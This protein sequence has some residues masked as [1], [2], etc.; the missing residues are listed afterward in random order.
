MSTNL[1]YHLLRAIGKAAVFVNVYLRV[2]LL[3]RMSK[4]VESM[5]RTLTGVASGC[6]VT[7]FNWPFLPLAR[8]RS[9][10]LNMALN[11]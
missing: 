4:K 10:C 9:G 8:L 1:D 11:I 2:P 7:Y 6:K 5:T 3:D